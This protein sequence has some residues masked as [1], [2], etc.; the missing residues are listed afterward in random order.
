[1]SRSTKRRR[2]KRRE[3]IAADKQ[4]R[5]NEPL[6]PILPIDYVKAAARFAC[7]RFRGGATMSIK[8][9]GPLVEASTPEELK[10]ETTEAL[11]NRSE[12]DNEN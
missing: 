7:L 6:L 2:E 11:R 1:L 9:L 10:T 4:L 8:P 12:N 5:A 3:R